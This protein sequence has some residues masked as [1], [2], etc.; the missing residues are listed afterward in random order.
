[1]FLLWWQQ[2]GLERRKIQWAPMN[3]IRPSEWFT[4]FFMEWVLNPWLS[5]WI[6]ARMKPGKRFGALKGAFLEL[7]LGSMGLF[8][9]AEREGR[10]F[11]M[12]SLVP[13]IGTNFKCQLVWLLLAQCFLLSSFFDLL[14]TWRYIN[15]G[16]LVVAASIFNFILWVIFLLSLIFNLCG[17]GM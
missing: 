6:A 3:G 13:F 12:F 8:L 1:M 4:A 14:I 10:D 17:S 16:Y 2:D 7:T 15:H 9:L 5:N 11:S